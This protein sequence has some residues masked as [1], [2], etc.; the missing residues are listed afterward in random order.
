MVLVLAVAAACGEE[1]VPEA[2]GPDV[3]SRRLPDAGRCVRRGRG[4][5]ARRARPRGR[6]HLRPDRRRSFPARPSDHDRRWHAGRRAAEAGGPRPLRASAVEL[7]DGGW[8]LA[9]VRAPPREKASA[10]PAALCRVTMRRSSGGSIR[11]I[12]G[13][14]TLVRCLT[15][16]ATPPSR[17]SGSAMVP[18]SC[19]S[20]AAGPTRTCLT[21]PSSWTGTTTV[22]CGGW[23]ATPRRT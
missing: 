9:G 17:S 18:P 23:L 12:G 13:G 14:P 19:G 11:R 5:P 2:A 15:S 10:R 22:G 16:C 21:G 8:L 4:V 6:G 7:P 1:V 3:S 20:A